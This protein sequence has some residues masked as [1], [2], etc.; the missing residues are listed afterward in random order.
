LELLPR[1]LSRAQNM[2]VLSSQANLAGYKSVLLAAAEYQRMFPVS[3]ILFPFYRCHLNIYCSV[4]GPRFTFLRS[5]VCSP[6]SSY[7]VWL[8]EFVV[9]KCHIS[10]EKYWWKVTLVSSL[11]NHSLTWVVLLPEALK[12]V[13]WN[14]NDII[15][16]ALVHCKCITLGTS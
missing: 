8:G 5:G 15:K 12:L 7:L 9:F 11:L 16:I 1:T 2:D 14:N 13:Q 6:W 10:Q 4:L 3:T